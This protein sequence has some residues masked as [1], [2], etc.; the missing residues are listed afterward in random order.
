MTQDKQKGKSLG[1]MAHLHGCTGPEACGSRVIEIVE[2]ERRRRR[3]GGSKEEWA[4][5]KEMADWLSSRFRHSYTTPAV[6]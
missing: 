2:M 5:A 3:E 6:L 1:L 4:Q